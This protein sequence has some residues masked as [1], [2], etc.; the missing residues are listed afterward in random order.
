M[1]HRQRRQNRVGLREAHRVGDEPAQSQEVLV[2]L[3]AELGQPGGPR[4][5]H[6]TGCVE[7]VLLQPGRVSQ[8]VQSGSGGGDDSS[9][10]AGAREVSSIHSGSV[11]MDRS[12]RHRRSVGSSRPDDRVRR[13]LV[14][15]LGQQL[16][17]IVGVH[18]GRLGSGQHQRQP[19]HQVGVRRGAYERY[20]LPVSR[21]RLL[22]RPDRAQ[23]QFR[24]LRSRRGGAAGHAEAGIGPPLHTVT[25]QFSQVPHAAPAPP[26]L[27]ASCPLY[28][29][30][31]CQFVG[32]LRPARELAAFC[33]L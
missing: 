14:Q 25:D 20:P 12:G 18:Q 1:E 16:V 6:P 23:G 8:P 15:H 26:E 17:G 29:A 3:L 13:E 5:V 30:F 4:R 10:L 22:Q 2:G 21:S 27:A 33:P 32:G 9:A 31:C 7:A 19:G 11:E 28:G 24:G